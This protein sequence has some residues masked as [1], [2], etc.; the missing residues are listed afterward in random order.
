MNVDSISIRAVTQKVGDLWS[1]IAE[2]AGEQI[3]FILALLSRYDNNQ[4]DQKDKNTQNQI[5]VSSEHV[6]MMFTASPKLL[7]P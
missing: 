1:V 2:D 3:I 7:I 5:N 6:H 4:C